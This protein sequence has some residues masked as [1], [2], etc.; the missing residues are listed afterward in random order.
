[1][2]GFLEYTEVTHAVGLLRADGE[3]P[4]GRCSNE[5]HDAIAPS[6]VWLQVRAL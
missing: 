3:W 6:H 5:K 4:G 1:M 2:L